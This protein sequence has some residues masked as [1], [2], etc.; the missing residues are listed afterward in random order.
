M[1]YSTG[2]V[3]QASDYNTFQTNLNNVWSTGSGNSGW[4]QTAIA[5]SV[6]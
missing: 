5:A 2:G 6:V 1:T 3:V 4:G